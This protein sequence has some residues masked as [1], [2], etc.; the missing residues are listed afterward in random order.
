MN[1]PRPAGKLVPQKSSG[2]QCLLL[3]QF[4]TP[5]L[6]SLMARRYVAGSIQLLL[7]IVGFL[8]FLGWFLQLF[9]GMYRMAA[10]LEDQPAQRSWLAW[11]GVLLFTAS[12]LLAWPTSISVLREGRKREAAERIGVGA[13]PVIQP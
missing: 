7:A 11:G 5:G 2:F 1:S 8:L 6:G 4:A 12:W 13:P 3:N 10:G 9:T